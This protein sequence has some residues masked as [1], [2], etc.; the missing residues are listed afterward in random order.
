VLH[1]VEVLWD[2]F[3]DDDYQYNSDVQPGPDEQLCLA[4]SKVAFSGLSAARTIR[5][6]AVIAGLQAQVLIDSSSSTSFLSSAVAAKLSLCKA[7][8][9]SSQ[10]H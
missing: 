3:V 4:L 10:V 9:Q 1:A 8:C 5:F 2:S 7:I 6:Q